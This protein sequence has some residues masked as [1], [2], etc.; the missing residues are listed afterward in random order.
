MTTSL[1]QV[2]IHQH[3]LFKCT[4]ECS[5]NRSYDRPQNKSKQIEES[6]YQ[7]ISNHNGMKKESITGRKSREK[8]RYMG[9]KQH[10]NKNKGLMNKSKKKM[11]NYLQTN[12]N[13]TQ[14]SKTYVMQQ[15]QI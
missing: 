11:K 5:Q 7:A 12:E 8:H 10:T 1:K 9:T 14:L 2:D 13:K 3:I 6:L 15:K 4:K